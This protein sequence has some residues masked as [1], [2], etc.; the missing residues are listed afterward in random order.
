MQEPALSRYTAPFGWSLAVCAVLNAVIVIAKEKSKSVNG[1][2]QRMTGHHW[3]THVLIVLLMFLALGFIFA[4]TNR[5][6]ETKNSG[7]RLARIVVAGVVA[8]VLIIG[9][10]YLIA[11]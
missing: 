4:Q 9:G 3:T 8:G 5:Q 10:F 11:D 7:D 1:W 6:G 2:M